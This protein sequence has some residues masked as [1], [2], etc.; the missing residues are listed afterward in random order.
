MNA[1]LRLTL[2]AIVMAAVLDVAYRVGGALGLVFVC[3]LMALL[4]PSLIEVLAGYPRF[5]TRIVMRKFEG[6]YY[7]FRGRSMDI[8]ID[9]QA[10]CWISTADVR[11]L[12][13]L[14]ADGVLWHLYPGECRESGDPMRWRITTRALTQFFAKAT[15]PDVTRL[16]R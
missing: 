13:A 2:G 16:S 12:T 11:K 1:P 9:D 14:P 7:E 3:P 4:G 6:R 15:D 8:E 5:V 10:R